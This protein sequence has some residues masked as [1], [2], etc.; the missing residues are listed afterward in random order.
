MIL[1]R[2]DSLDRGLSKLQEL[3][4]ENDFITYFFHGYSWNDLLA[5]N[6]LGIT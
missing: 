1:N 2:K 3:K 6:H 4:I 5:S